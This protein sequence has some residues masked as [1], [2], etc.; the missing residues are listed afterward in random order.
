MHSTVVG[1]S[2]NSTWKMKVQQS[3]GEKMEFNVQ[4]REEGNV[5]QTNRENS[6]NVFKNQFGPKCG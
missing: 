4:I 5:K 2:T 6:T 3:K 1:S